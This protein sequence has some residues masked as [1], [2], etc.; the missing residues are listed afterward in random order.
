MD[1]DFEEGGPYATF[2]IVMERSV[3]QLDAQLV[4]LLPSAAK[5]LRRVGGKLEAPRW[6]LHEPYE[7]KLTPLGV[8][9]VQYAAL[10]IALL[11]HPRFYR[12]GKLLDLGHSLADR[13]QIESWQSFAAREHPRLEGSWFLTVD[14]SP[15]EEGSLKW[16]KRFKPY[17]PWI[18]ITLT[19]LAQGPTIYNN[20]K[21]IYA[22]A[23]LEAFEASQQYAEIYFDGLQEILDVAVQPIGPEKPVPQKSQPAT[24]RKRRSKLGRS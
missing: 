4:T 20:V 2:R 7:P 5:V 1:I 15:I 10:T 14:L 11:D 17:A 16:L 12:S 9:F 13:H 6:H 19:G 23:V 24:V 8:G 21:D 22:P 18:G 3:E